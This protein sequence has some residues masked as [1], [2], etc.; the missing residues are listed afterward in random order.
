MRYSKVRVLC[1]SFLL[2]LS[3]NKPFRAHFYQEAF[4]VALASDEFPMLNFL[5][6]SSKAPHFPPKQK[7]K[8]KQNKIP[9]TKHKEAQLEPGF[10]FSDL[11][12]NHSLAALPHVSLHKFLNL[13]KSVPSSV[14]PRGASRVASVIK[15]LTANAR[16]IKDMGSTAGSGRS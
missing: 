10:G 16:D 5:F 12:A 8:Q 1:T 15:H 9:K 11:S 2:L 7:Q 4:P 14:D 13:A 3:H 6:F